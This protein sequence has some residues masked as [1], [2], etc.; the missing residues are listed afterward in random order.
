RILTQVPL[1]RS[2]DSFE[3]DIVSPERMEGRPIGEILDG[4]IG[5]IVPAP[6]LDTFEKSAVVEITVVEVETSLYVGPQQLALEQRPGGR[7]HRR[8]NL[9]RWQLC[10]RRSRHEHQGSQANHPTE[11]GRHGLLSR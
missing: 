1:P 11:D 9:A 10:G 6:T 2:L 5:T 7:S 4:I 3:D 8:G